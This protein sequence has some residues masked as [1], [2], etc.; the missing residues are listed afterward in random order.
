MRI[1]ISVNGLSLSILL[2][3]GVSFCGAAPTLSAAFFTNFKGVVIGFDTVES[4]EFSKIS[5]NFI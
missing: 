1:L 4:T 3:P 2:K 5:L